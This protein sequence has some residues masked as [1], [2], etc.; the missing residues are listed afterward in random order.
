MESFFSLVF[1]VRDRSKPSSVAAT[2]SAGFELDLH[3][4]TPLPSGTG[5]LDLE[6]DRG[7]DPWPWIVEL[8]RVVNGRSEPFRSLRIGEVYKK[9][10]P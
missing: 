6:T 1:S 3:L 4:S 9:L 2:R 8:R 7:A 5:D 10:S